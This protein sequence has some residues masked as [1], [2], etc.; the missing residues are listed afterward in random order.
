MYPTTVAA[1]KCCIF[2]TPL[3]SGK[4]NRLFLLLHQRT[5]GRRK[6]Y[7]VIMLGC[8]MW[9]QHAILSV[10][11]CLSVAR[12]SSLRSLIPG[13]QKLNNHP[14]LVALTGLR[15]NTN[16]GCFFFCIVGSEKPWT[17]ALFHII[18]FVDRSGTDYKGCLGG[19]VAEWCGVSWAASDMLSGRV[20]LPAALIG[21]LL[22]GWLVCWLVVIALDDELLV[23]ELV[24]VLLPNF[25]SGN[26]NVATFF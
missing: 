9:K 15:S 20:E 7:P 25:A 8:K 21:T 3:R 22:A 11:L 2:T 1:K 14:A 16:P 5:P 18:N 10:V 13:F 17:R 4:E 12:D 6:H 24:G 26:K 19:K 23:Y